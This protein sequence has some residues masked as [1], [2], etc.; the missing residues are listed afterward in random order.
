[1]SFHISS[2]DKPLFCKVNSSLEK[3]LFFPNN[4]IFLYFKNGIYQLWDILLDKLIADGFLDK[5]LKF[6]LY[7]SKIEVAY[8]SLSQQEL[9]IHN[10]YDH[11]EKK[12]SAKVPTKQA[13]A[14]NERTESAL[15][16]MHDENTSFEVL[17]DSRLLAVLEQKNSQNNDDVIVTVF[18]ETTNPYF[19]QTIY[20]NAL[21][22]ILKMSTVNNKDTLVIWSE[23][24]NEQ[25]LEFSILNV[26]KKDSGFKVVTMQSVII[27]CE[28]LQ[29][30]GWQTNQLFILAN[31]N[32]GPPF[33]KIIDYVEENQVLHIDF[34]PSL[35][36]GKPITITG[37]FFSDWKRN[38]L[39]FSTESV[40]GHF[41][42]L[43][44][45]E[46]KTACNRPLKD[47]HSLIICREFS[48][49]NDFFVEY[50][51]SVGNVSA[52]SDEI[53]LKVC[54][55]VNKGNF[56]FSLLD[57]KKVISKYGKWVTQEVLNF[58]G[59]KN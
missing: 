38:L 29:V 30:F 34:S 16:S 14:D 13:L 51:Y 20:A 25:P 9:R 48:L 17:S 33:L 26:L 7:F 44:D 42:C 24:F 23:S 49:F 1:M 22:K 21:K 43:F 40:I 41:I 45:V 28:I 46:K 39:I 57:K 15:K 35:F 50:E 11:K 6:L 12:L 8:Y 58:L 3:L 59:L 52:S 56:V 27:N 32:V 54:S 53:Y 31:S 36:Y 47:E 55:F 37:Y 4:Q 5:D 18:E 10:I 19:Y 2:E